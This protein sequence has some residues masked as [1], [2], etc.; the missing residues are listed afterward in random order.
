MYVIY[1]LNYNQQLTFENNHPSVELLL[2]PDV[3][4]S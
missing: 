2:W 1:K 3:L 4:F